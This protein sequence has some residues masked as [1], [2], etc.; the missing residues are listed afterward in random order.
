MGGMGQEKVSVGN[1]SDVQSC[2]AKNDETCLIYGLMYSYVLYYRYQR[3][4]QIYE[5]LHPNGGSAGATKASK[6]C[7][8]EGEAVHIPKKKRRED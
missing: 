3:D 8:S 2:F 1:S 5:R 7:N 4:V 6:R